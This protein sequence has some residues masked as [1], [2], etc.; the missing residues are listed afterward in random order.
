MSTID[1]SRLRV[2]GGTQ[3]RAEINRDVVFPLS[4]RDLHSSAWVGHALSEDGIVVALITG[5]YT[6]PGLFMVRVCGKTTSQN[7]RP[8][9]AETV[10]V[11]VATFLERHGAD[12][13]SVK[14]SASEDF[15]IDTPNDANG[16]G[17]AI[18]YFL[19]AG[20]FIK[21]GK[22]TGDAGTRVAQLQT[23]CPYHIEII[24]EI[25]G[26]YT[27]ETRLHRQFRH[28]HAY[29]EWF[30]DAPELRSYISSILTEGRRDPH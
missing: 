9:R 28:I 12:A 17:G 20:P 23:G 11:Y 1:I 16:K 27:L 8:I 14:W 3:S 19:A 21:I 22:A 25:P 10:G 2:N 29:G 26:G 18:V 5:S 15:P 13:S 6:A 30:H 7:V 4:D 24:G